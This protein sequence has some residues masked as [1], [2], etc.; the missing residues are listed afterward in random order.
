MVPVCF[1]IVYGYDFLEA[2]VQVRI[3]PTITAVCRILLSLVYNIVLL[4]VY[5]NSDI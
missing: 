3:N 2:K 5:C 4:S 1:Y